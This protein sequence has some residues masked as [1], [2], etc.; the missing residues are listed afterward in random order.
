MEHW[1]EQLLTHLNLAYFTDTVK[2]YA[3]VEEDEEDEEDEE[4]GVVEGGEEEEEIE[5]KQ[6]KKEEEKMKRLKRGVIFI[7]GGGDIMDIETSQSKLT[8]DKKGLSCSAE[9][10]SNYLIVITTFERCAQQFGGN[11]DHIL[12]IAGAAITNLP[13]HTRWGVS[14]LLQIRW[15][16]L[17]V[18]EGIF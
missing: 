11:E 17:I 5:D 2:R 7:D 18:D 15:L 12:N 8:L 3:G 4:E 16:R 9:K 1:Y 14:P 13:E 10:L 6:K